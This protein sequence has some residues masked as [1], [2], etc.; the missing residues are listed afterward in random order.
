MADSENNT[1]K[2]SLTRFSMR[3][4][5]P[6]EEKILA[7]IDEECFPEEPWTEEMFRHDLEDNPFSTI[8]LAETEEDGS[9]MGYAGVW[10]IGE[11]GHITNVAVRPPYRGCGLARTLLQLLEHVAGQ[12]NV[13]G[14]TLEVR[15]SNDAAIALYESCGFKEEG[16]RKHYYENNGEDALIMWKRF[17]Q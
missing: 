17:N 13:T 5:L 16:R 7:A 9:I 10:F 15:P 14:L 1:K 3:P 11:E 2:K 6:G 8:F 4:A 12:M